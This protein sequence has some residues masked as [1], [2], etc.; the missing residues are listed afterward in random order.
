M[1][2]Y[3][4]AAIA[5]YK[6]DSFSNGTGQ[7]GP[8]I[9]PFH[10]WGNCS[11]RGMVTC[12]TSWG[13]ARFAGQCPLLRT[14]AGMLAL[15]CHTHTTAGPGCGPP[16]PPYWSV[17]CFRE[18]VPSMHQGRMSSCWLWRGLQP[19]SGMLTLVLRLAFLFLFG[20]LSA[21][22]LRWWAWEMGAG[23]WSR[24][25]CCWLPWWPAS[26]SWAST[27]GS[28]APGAWI[29]RFGLF[30][31]LYECHK[32]FNVAGWWGWGVCCF[33]PPKAL[34]SVSCGFGHCVPHTWPWALILPVLLLGRTGPPVT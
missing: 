13:S 12:L 21:W 14:C 8:L 26:L 32:A 29:S 20:R 5:V 25:P 9:S 7:V 18:K 2:K 1:W 4:R 6:D 30:V 24:R 19:A 16:R 3:L 27:I 28:R 33:L 17:S 11:E 23:A 31:C 22:P 10:R 34:C 15:L